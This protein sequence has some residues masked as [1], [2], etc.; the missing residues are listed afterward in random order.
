M[1][2]F[3]AS[4]L[5]GLP[6]TRLLTL[7]GAGDEIVA[8][9]TIYG[10]TYA[11]LKN[12]L[13]RFGVTTRFVNTGDLAAVP[14]AGMP[15][16]LLLMQIERHVRLE[17]AAA[18]A[19]VGGWYFSDGVECTFPPGTRIAS[20][21][22]MVSPPVRFAPRAARGVVVHPNNAVVRGKHAHDVVLAGR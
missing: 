6:R 17:Q 7:T 1:S 19:D 5:E 20:G 14:A 18:E 12:L 4:D 22:P 3:R 13:P 10:G 9:R 15:R 11:L 16:D 21:E 8:S 2:G